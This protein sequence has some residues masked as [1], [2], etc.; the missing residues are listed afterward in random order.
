M[1]FVCG[2]RFLNFFIHNFIGLHAPLLW[3]NT[4]C[5][6]IYLFLLMCEVWCVCVGCGVCGECV[7]CVGSGVMCV[8]CGCQEWCVCVCR[9]WCE[10]VLCLTMLSILKTSCRL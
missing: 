6:V 2:V 4:T 5:I 10:C 1:F 8:L 7:V 9:M 3:S